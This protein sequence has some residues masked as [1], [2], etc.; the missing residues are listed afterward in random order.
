MKKLILVFLAVFFSLSACGCGIGA[1]FR[2][3]TNVG[4]ILPQEEDDG[5][6]DEN[7]AGDPSKIEA[8]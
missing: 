3:L 7:N 8:L 6:E 1:I 5:K 2:N 4:C